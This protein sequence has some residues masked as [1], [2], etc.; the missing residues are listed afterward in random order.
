MED[1]NQAISDDDLHG[2]AG[3]GRAHSIADIVEP[4]GAPLVDPLADSRR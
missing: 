1:L 4:D 2:F 3:E